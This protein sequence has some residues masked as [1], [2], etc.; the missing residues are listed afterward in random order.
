MRTRDQ[1]AAYSGNT[2][3]GADKWG[4]VIHVSVG[5]V[6]LVYSIVDY[7]HCLNHQA[8]MSQAKKAC[9]LLSCYHLNGRSCYKDMMN[10]MTTRFLSYISLNLAFL[11]INF[12]R[13]LNCP[14]RSER[15]TRREIASLRT[16][17]HE[18]IP[19][20]C[21][22]SR[23]LATEKSLDGYQKGIASGISRFA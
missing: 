6:L 7:F 18:T 2:P 1:I 16:Q 14:H 21:V 10:L 17:W 19:C 23:H 13:E 20:H 4:K 11:V 8:I 15:E 5:P 22:R 3:F 12:V 9:D